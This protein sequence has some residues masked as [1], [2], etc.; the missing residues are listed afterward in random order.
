MPTQPPPTQPPPTRPPIQLP[1]IFYV[2]T[3]A[4]SDRLLL[5]QTPLQSDHTVTYP[6][7]TASFLY[8]KFSPC[9]FTFIIVTKGFSKSTRKMPAVRQSERL[10]QGYQ[11][12]QSPLQTALQLGKQGADIHARLFTSLIINLQ[13]TVY[14]TQTQSCFYMPHQQPTDS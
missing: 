1:L 4:I 8:S 9:H 3:S 7:M 6:Y 2:V 14:F 5:I 13:Q 11:L 12:S 10:Q